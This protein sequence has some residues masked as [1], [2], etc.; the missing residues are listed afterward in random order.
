MLVVVDE[1]FSKLEF[2]IDGNGEVQ[3][4]VT[5][6]HTDWLSIEISYNNYTLVWIIEACDNEAGIMKKISVEFENEL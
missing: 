5:V 6:N 4:E 2:R 3:S 1:T